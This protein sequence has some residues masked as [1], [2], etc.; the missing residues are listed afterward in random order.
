MLRR[1][2]LKLG[3]ALALLPVAALAA[4]PPRSLWNVR[5]FG[6]SGDGRTIDSDAFNRAIL[7]AAAA[8]GGT[9]LVP[10]GEYLCRS[11]RLRS[12]ICL[13]LE[14]GATIVAAEPLPEGQSGGYDPPEPVQPWEAYQDYGHNHWHNSLIWGEDLQDVSI[15]GPGQIHGRGLAT[16]DVS[17]KPRTH[18]GGNKAI[19]LKN[20]RNVLLAD[21]QILEGGWFG[22]L[23]TAVDELK[24]RALTIDTSRD[25]MDI[26]CCQ[27]VHISDCSV[28]S[29][30]DDA[31]VLKSSFA[32]GRSRD[33]RNVTITG[34]YV[35]AAFRV[36]T[37][38]DGTHIPQDDRER[39]WRTGRIKLGTE[40]N[41]GFTNIAIT[42]CIFEGC[43]GLALESEDGARLEDVV[44]SNL[45]M[46]DVSTAPIFIRLGS[47][48]RGPR[49]SAVGTVRRVS[50]SNVVCSNANSHNGCVIS[51]IPGYA[52][53][54]LSLSNIL[55]QHQGGGT[56]E[57]AARRP[58]ELET[59]YPDPTMFGDMPSQGFY[60]RHARRVQLSGIRVESLTA[61]QRPSF[62]LEQLEEVNCDGIY[63]HEQPGVPKFVLDG[64]RNFSLRACPGVPDLQLAEVGHRSF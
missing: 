23:A 35:T 33:T 53:E 58:A 15:V 60:I 29:P 13:R 7:A 36:G 52:I 42:N 16:D 43:Q 18:N 44:V 1:D 39:S 48:L 54:D 57:Q 22:I 55:I 4:E 49:G 41:G 9:V 14:Q 6:A 12:N 47:R 45:T 37:L 50:I 26:D 34:C 24:I 56:A 61:D 40:S 46:R 21:F 11:I 25:G 27:D 31:I 38:L 59:A 5:E 28:N 20:C 64:V 8:G 10:A 17:S 51:G 30:F 19:A 62:M 2:F 3:G 63:S 32:L